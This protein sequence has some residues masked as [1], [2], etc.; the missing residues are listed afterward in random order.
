MN[1]VSSWP[2]SQEAELVDASDTDEVVD[3]DTSEV[4]IDDNEVDVVVVVLVV[5]GVVFKTGKI[6]AEEINPAKFANW[7]A[8]LQKHASS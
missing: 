6:L 7:F 8:S 2:T 1:T 5:D 4:D 3:D